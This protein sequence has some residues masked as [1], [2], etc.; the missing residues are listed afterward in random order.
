MKFYKIKK[1]YSDIFNLYRCKSLI[2]N[3]YNYTFEHSINYVYAMYFPIINY[4]AKVSAFSI[5]WKS[6][7]EKI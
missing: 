2:S 3:Y 7:H 4:G 6:L 5:P 1:Q